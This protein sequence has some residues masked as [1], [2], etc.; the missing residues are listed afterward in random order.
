MCPSSKEQLASETSK[1][2]ER[3]NVD[4]Q[5]VWR[6]GSRGRRGSGESLDEPRQVLAYAKRELDSIIASANGRCDS[7][8][9]KGEI[10]DE[11]RK[12]DQRGK[13]R[14]SR[15]KCEGEAAGRPCKD[16]AKQLSEERM[17]GPER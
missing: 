3:A 8:Q 4:A 10:V 15:L 9:R 12:E 14:R 13:S 6:G 5:S 2:R 17:G 11:G 7:E 1:I 16:P